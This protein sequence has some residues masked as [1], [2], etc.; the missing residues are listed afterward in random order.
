MNRTFLISGASFAG[1]TLA[2][3]LNKFDYHVTLV[4]IS[5]GIR[6]GGSPIEIRS[7]AL[8]IVQEMG[9]LEKIKAKQLTVNVNK[10]MVNAKDETLFSWNHSEGND[11]EI[12]RDDLLDILEESIPKNVEFL[13]KNRITRLEQFEDNV[14]VT[15]KNGE[16]RNFDFVIGADGTHSSVRKLIFGNENEFS[17]FF[18]AYFATCEMKDIATNQG[19]IYNEPGKMAGLFPFKNS[20]QATLIFRSPK[21]NYDYRSLE[22]Q[23]EILKT[24]FKNGAWKIQNIID[25]MLKSDKVY[26]D[27]I[28]QIKMPTWSKD[29]IALVGDAAHT[30]GFPTGMGTTLAI[31]GSAILA[32][33]LNELQGD[34][35]AAFSNY[36]K[37]YHPFAETVQA[38]ITDGLNFTVPETQ[39]EI[40]RRFNKKT[41]A[42][43]AH[44]QAD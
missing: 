22:E 42:N 28:C 38:K 21:L 8:N 19:V 41:T 18:G 27:E 6:K 31:Q 24:N 34:F 25:E 30:A 14:N 15:F 36:Y 37:I 5:S 39:E 3:W 12:D 26:F 29:R 4:E 11:I 10:R 44:L 23:K 2:Y 33:S 32:K 35:Q 9:L 1:L 20:V 16:N 13:Y 43:N 7:E 40:D 17:I